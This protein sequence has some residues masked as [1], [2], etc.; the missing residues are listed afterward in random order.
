MRHGGIATGDAAAYREKAKQ[1]YDG[2]CHRCGGEVAW[3]DIEVHHVDRNRANDNLDNLECLCH[4][5]HRAEHHGE[6]PLWRLVCSMPR[7]VLELLD[8]AV[9]R[10]GYR[11]RSEA[12]CRAVVDAHA[13]TDDDYFGGPVES[14]SCW[15]S[16]DRHTKWV[17]DAVVEPPKGD[18]DER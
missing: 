3:E 14:V 1:D 17:S 5:C 16:D 4:E 8:E 18:D 2:S 12:V 10:N 6:D 9:E 7:P 13:S 11:S 15:F